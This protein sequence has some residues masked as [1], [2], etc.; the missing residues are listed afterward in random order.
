MI[1]SVS[2]INLVSVNVLCVTCSFPFLLYFSFENLFRFS[3][4]VSF[5]IIHISLLV[6]VSVNEYITGGDFEIYSLTDREP[7]EIGK[8][9]RCGD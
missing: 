7:V 9:L 2:K 6:S 3:S 8:E 5:Q 1:I 4:V